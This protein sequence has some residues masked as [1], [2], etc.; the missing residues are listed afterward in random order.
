MTL[1]LKEIKRNSLDIK[2]RVIEELITKK[3]T[4]KRL[5]KNKNKQLKATNTLKRSFNCDV[6]G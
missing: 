5:E 2:K 3:I 1:Y 6:F 4:I